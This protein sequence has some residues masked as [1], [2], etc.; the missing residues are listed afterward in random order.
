MQISNSPLG[1]WYCGV[2][3]WLFSAVLF[4]AEDSH[5][6]DAA[7]TNLERVQVAQPERAKLE[8]ERLFAVKEQLNNEQLSRLFVSQSI[9][10]MLATEFQLALDLLQKAERLTT[11]NTRLTNNYLYQATAFT[12]LGEYESAL[13][14]IAKNLSKIEQ[15]DELD[16]KI[17]SYLRLTNLYANLEAYSE[18]SHYAQLVWQMSKGLDPLNH[19][20]ASLFIAVAALKQADFKKAEKLFQTAQDFCA[21]SNIPLVVAMAEKG[22]AETHLKRGSYAEALQLLLAAQTGYQ[23][24]DFEWELNNVTALLAE[25]YYHLQQPA[26]AQLAANTIM[27][28]PEASVNIENKV[29]ASKVLAYLAHAEGNYQQAYD[30]LALHQA[31]AKTLLDE[32]KAKAQAYH[33]AKFENGEMTRQVRMLEQDR[34][35]YNA[36]QELK[37]LEDSRNSMILLVTLGGMVLVSIFGITTLVQKQRYKKLAQ[38]DPLTGAY[39]RGIGQELAENIYVKTVA[40]HKPFSVI[41]LDLDN[42]KLINDSYGH[43]AGDWSLKQVAKVVRKCVSSQDMLVRM[44]GEEF[45]IFLPNRDSETAQQVAELCRE[46]IAA[47]EG[48]YNNY[49]FDITASFGVTSNLADDLSLDPITH[50]ADLAMYRAKKAGRNTVVFQLDNSGETLPNAYQSKFALG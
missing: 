46:G 38:F 36:R 19:C 40:Y 6:Y 22:K 27:A 32:T 9:V 11:S 24:F 14:I 37:A 28:L 8:L 39:N 16:I 5:N 48:K 35:L 10:H 1:G 29:I 18:M 33:M 17:S 7:L 30:S 34:E 43:H 13:D 25:T 2:V 44:G 20:Y 50:R 21:A 23:S 3:L 15:L 26:Q 31:L 12:G 47:I 49:T 41:I 4:A 45:A 42:F